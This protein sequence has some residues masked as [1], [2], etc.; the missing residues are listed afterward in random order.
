MDA[1]EGSGRDIDALQVEG[2]RIDVAIG[3]P[4]PS[5]HECRGD[6]GRRGE[7]GL[8]EVLAGALLIV[9][10]AQHIRRPYVRR[11]YNKRE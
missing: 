3:R 8:C 6:D 11:E 10:V 5:L 2:L 1:R 4:G 9:A 7:A